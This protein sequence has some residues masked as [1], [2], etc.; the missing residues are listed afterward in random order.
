MREKRYKC[1]SCRVRFDSLFVP[2]KCPSC[3]SAEVVRD[4]SSI[5]FITSKQVIGYNPQ[6]GQEAYERY[7]RLEDQRRFCEERLQDFYGT[8]IR[9]VEEERD[10][11]LKEVLGES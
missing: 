3:S 11:H 2:T 6:F 7:P 8:D 1:K 4:F 10:V 5:G 9:V